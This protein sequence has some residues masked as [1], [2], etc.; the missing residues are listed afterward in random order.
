MQAIKL[1]DQVLASL[2]TKAPTHV[3]IT[4]S[5]WDLLSAVERAEHEQNLRPQAD[6][7]AA[8]HQKPARYGASKYGRSAR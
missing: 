3:D 1:R 8:A 6:A 5:M 2:R 4:M 7:W